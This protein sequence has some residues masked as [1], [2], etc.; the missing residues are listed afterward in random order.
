[1]IATMA[2]TKVRRN[3]TPRH[4]S[5]LSSWDSEMHSGRCLCAF[6]LSPTGHLLEPGSLSLEVQEVVKRKCLKKSE[7][8]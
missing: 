5:S 8:R 6:R 1:M 4:Q 3:R 2:P 7:S